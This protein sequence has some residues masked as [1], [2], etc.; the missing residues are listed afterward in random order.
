ME[1]AL[2]GPRTVNHDGV[3]YYVLHAPAHSV[4]I[5]WKSK[6]GAPLRTFPRAARFLFSQSEQP[7]TLMNGGIFD[8]GKIPSGLLI[9][10]SIETELE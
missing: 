8:P 4:R 5:I 2:A 10:D 6:D 1:N 9:Q 3:T 7:Q